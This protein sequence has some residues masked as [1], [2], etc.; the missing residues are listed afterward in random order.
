MAEDSKKLTFF[1]EELDR[2]PD[3]RS[4]VFPRGA[5]HRRRKDD[6]R[7]PHEGPPEGST[8]PPRRPERFSRLIYTVTVCPSCLYSVY[9]PDFSEVPEKIKQQLRGTMP[10]SGPRASSRSST[11]SIS[12][13][14]SDPE[15]RRSFLFLRGHVLRSFHEGVHSHHQ[16]GLSAV[17]GP[18]GSATTCTASS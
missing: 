14:P 15:G 18:P 12:H 6:R 5:S 16:A 10:N 9:A 3:L 13:P 2:V 8:S 7:R 4:Q 17:S 1:R 11:T